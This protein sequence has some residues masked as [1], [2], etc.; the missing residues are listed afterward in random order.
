MEK[1]KEFTKMLVETRERIEDER[2]HTE[3]A[4]ERLKKTGMVEV[5][6]TKACELALKNVEICR[7][8]WDDTEG[9]IKS[10]EDL[11][12]AIAEENTLGVFIDNY[13]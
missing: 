10:E 2:A 7:L 5:T 12:L 1:L 9:V 3:D 6:P 4:W 11:L 13:M 8:Y